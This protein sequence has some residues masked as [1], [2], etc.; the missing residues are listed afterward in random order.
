MKELIKNNIKSVKN[1]IDSLF[2]F[3]PRRFTSRENPFNRP[4]VPEISLADDDLSAMPDDRLLKLWATSEWAEY[5]A[6]I[7]H[8]D[9]LSCGDWKQMREKSLKFKEKPLISVIIPTFNTEL[10]MLWECI[11]SVQAQAYPCWEMC[12]VDDG[13]THS[14][15]VEQLK[16]T[17]GADPRVKL[18]LS[19]KNRGICHATNIALDMASGQYLAFLDH[20]DRLSVAAFYYVVKAVNQDPGLDVIYSDRD[21]LSPRGLRFMHLFKPDYSPEL[22]FSM[23]YI[24]HLMV[25]RKSLVDKVGGIHPEFEGS[26][27][28]DLILRV[29]ELTDRIHHIPKILYHWRQSDQS[30]AL[31]HNVKD[32]AYKAGVHALKH[33]LKRRG[34][35]GR[36]SEI[37]DLWRGHYRVHLT[38]PPAESVSIH[39]IKNSISCEKYADAL[40]RKYAE[41]K[42]QAI[43]VFIGADLVPVDKWALQE[44]VS[45]FQ[46][47][48]IG[49]VTGRII[50]ADS[51][52]I[53]A[54]MVQKQDGAPLAIYEGGQ[55]SDPGYI[56]STAVVKNVSA[57]HPWCF[58]VRR[59]VW[60]MLGGLSS[61]YTGPHTIIDLALR[62]CQKGYRTVFT[63]FASFVDAKVTIPAMYS[64]PEG[65]KKH[66]AMKWHDWLTKGDPYYNKNLTLKLGDMGLEYCI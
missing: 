46:V 19:T 4:C 18:F 59:D 8:N 21:M 61:D 5:Q 44:M 39:Y 37:S 6:W 45:W 1:I 22:L 38:P 10:D 36:V 66:F 12:I 64:W 52:I 24:C 23:N 54:G 32:Y 56:A 41:V 48:G 26:Q 16:N 7:F 33:A 13:S 9:F 51:R 49:L 50:D 29:M 58:A 3:R 17:A 30:V 11:R 62:A 42:E 65:D 47:E 15:T 55:A 53:H 35:N 14:A 20:D 34:L 57:P 27:D 2:L 40:K 28:Y 63:P 25:Y 43:L 31:N 60:E